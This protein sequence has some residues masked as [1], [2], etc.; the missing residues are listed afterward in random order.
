MQAK[1]FEFKRISWPKS[2]MTVGQL[3]QNGAIYL[4]MD[5][6]RWPIPL[7]LEDLSSKRLLKK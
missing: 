3:Y 7:G 4:V 1:S 6:F 2:G 5:G